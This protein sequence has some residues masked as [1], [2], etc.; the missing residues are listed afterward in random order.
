MTDVAARGLDVPLLDNVVNFDFPTKPKLFVHRAGRAARAG[1]AGRALSLVEPEELPYLVDLHL[2]LGRRLRPVPLGGWGA[3][4]PVNEEG[5]DDPH[6]VDLAVFPPSVLEAEVEYANEAVA[7]NPDMEN[8]YDVATRSLQMV[9]KT[10]AHASKASV[11][12]ARELPTSLGIHPL[13]DSGVDVAK[14]TRRSSLLTQVRN[15]HPAPTLILPPEPGP[16][17]APDA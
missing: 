10:R 8:L 12:R 3:A 2:Y 4:G 1:R 15:P 5:V 7:A 9:R 17:P 16:T 14:E 11:A 6:A 13:A